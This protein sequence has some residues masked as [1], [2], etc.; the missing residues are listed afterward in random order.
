MPRQRFD[1]T[2]QRL[3]RALATN[4][5]VHTQ[6]FARLAPRLQTRLLQLRLERA[7]QRLDQGQQRAASALGRVA[8]GRRTRIERVSALLTP[9]LL[10]N[11]LARL[12]QALDGDTKMLAALSYQSVLRRG[13]ALVRDAEG[14]AVRS[15]ASL[16]A[17]DH[18]AM[19]F[20]DGSV[21]AEVTSSEQMSLKRDAHTPPRPPMKRSPGQSGGSQGSLF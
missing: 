16:Q 1:A 8:Q 14:K 10:A 7:R 6:R 20:S 13:F 18:I 12:R 17:G 15:A 4:T 9:Q 5:N 11:R 3:P 19:E 21:G 2:A